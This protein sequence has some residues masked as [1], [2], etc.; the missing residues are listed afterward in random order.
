LPLY[1]SLTVSIAVTGFSVAQN[2][3]VDVVTPL[4]KLDV[5]GGMR[6]GTTANGVAGSMRWNGTNF[7]VHNG[8]QWITFGTGTDND[9]TI[10]G[11]DLYSAVSGNVGI[12]SSTP[13]QKLQMACLR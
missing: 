10:S 4:Q 6:L 7:Q 12:G 8:I 5:A 3:G 11:L 1:L 9:W 13:G 2:V